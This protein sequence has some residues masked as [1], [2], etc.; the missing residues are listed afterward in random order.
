MPNTFRFVRWVP[1]Q[2][3]E[4]AIRGGLLSH[5]KSAMWIFDLSQA[6][7]PGNNISRGA[8]LIA[9][10]VDK[11]A[12]DNIKNGTTIDFENS[13]FG[14]EAA[15]P[16]AVIIKKNE[17]GAYGLGRQ[18]QGVTNLHCTTGYATKKEVAKALGLNEREVADNYKPRTGWGR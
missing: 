10:T 15:H 11:T 4:A 12:H 8:I 14:G 9:F 5:N 3:E 7:R 16:N 18:R 6:Y 2:H 13:S 1:K 17:P